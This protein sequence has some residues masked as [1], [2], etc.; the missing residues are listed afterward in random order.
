M[1]KIKKSFWLDTEEAKQV[2]ILAK[3]LKVS[4]SQVL[5]WQQQTF[6]SELWH[7]TLKKK[8]DEKNNYSR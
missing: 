8:I 2:E 4:E 1:A 6:T 7:Q 3:K 5:R